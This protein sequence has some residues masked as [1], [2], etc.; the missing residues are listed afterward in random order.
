MQLTQQISPLQSAI[1][2]LSQGRYY[3]AR[4]Q[5]VLGKAEAALDEFVGA[6]MNISN[7]NAERNC[8]RHGE[9]LSIKAR[10]SS[11]YLERGKVNQSAYN[12]ALSD[13]IPML[14][15]AVAQAGEQSTK[16]KISRALDDLRTLS[17]NP[18]LETQIGA[19]DGALTNDATPRLEI[20]KNDADGQDVSEH[21]RPLWNI[22]ENSMTSLDRSRDLAGREEA[23]VAS[24]VA[25]LEA[26]NGES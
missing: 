18:E 23:A 20:V 1:K 2:R 12:G 11:R 26:A 14:E 7:D 13:S 19:V 22:F 21:G 5:E 6:A 8:S 10:K 3:A 24:L 16:L 25:R 17:A 15:Q 9:E 4:T